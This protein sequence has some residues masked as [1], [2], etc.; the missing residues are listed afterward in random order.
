MLITCE[1]KSEHSMLNQK[2]QHVG[3]FC[4]VCPQVVGFVCTMRNRHVCF[5]WIAVIIWSHVK[6][7]LNSWCGPIDCLITLFT[8][9]HDTQPTCYLYWTDD[10]GSDAI[11]LM[12][13]RQSVPCWHAFSAM[14]HLRLSFHVFWCYI[15]M[16]VLC[17]TCHLEGGSLKWWKAGATHKG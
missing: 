4:L 7:N 9:G 1:V 13:S 16:F 5:I 10:V 14:L 2:R 8:F 3:A 12:P 15:L 11:H 17:L 6:W